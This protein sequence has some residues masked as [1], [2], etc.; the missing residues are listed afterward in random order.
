MKKIF[1][2]VLTF[3]FSLPLFADPKNIVYNETFDFSAIE[4]LNISLT[5]ENLQ[6]SRIYGD[7]IVI[8][9]GSNNIKKIPDVLMQDETLRIISKEQKSSRGY[10]CSVYVYLPQD[11]IAQTIELHNVSGTITA[12]VLQTQNAVLINNVSGRSDIKACQTELFTASSVSGNLTLQKTAVDYFVLGSTSG[13]LFVELEGAP[14]ATSQITNISGKTQLYYPKTS[15]FEITA[16][17]ISG[18]IKNNSSNNQNPGTNYQTTI[19]TGGP[20]LSI[21]SVSGKI[22]IVGY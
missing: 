6:I 10:K 18:S 13:N 4:N 15:N 21:T 2:I 16:F 12:D 22:E 19:G 8:E 5:Y 9:I 7:E 11:F 1:I 17:A 14:L 3:L 20:Q